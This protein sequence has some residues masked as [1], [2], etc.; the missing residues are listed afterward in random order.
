MQDLS[1][2]YIEFE[3]WTPLHNQIQYPVHPS[4]VLQRR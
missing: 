4:G 2:Q 3:S 1:I